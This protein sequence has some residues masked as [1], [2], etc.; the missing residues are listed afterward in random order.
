MKHIASANFVPSARDFAGTAWINLKNASETTDPYV[1]N[2]R[3]LVA[4]QD[5]ESAGETLGADLVAEVVSGHAYFSHVVPVILA[6]LEKKYHF[7]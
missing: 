4:R 7:S 1:R 3:L 6:Y 5:L 2:E